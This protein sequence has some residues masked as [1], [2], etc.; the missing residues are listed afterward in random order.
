[1]NSF[2]DFVKNIKKDLEEKE[3]VEQKNKQTPNSLNETKPKK[4]ENAN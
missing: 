4:E 1:M 2:D 3:Q